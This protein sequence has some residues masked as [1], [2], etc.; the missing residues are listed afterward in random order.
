[1]LLGVFADDLTGAT[2]IAGFLANGGLDVIQFIGVPDSPLPDAD[3]AV[4]SLKSRS[5]PARQAI[6]LSLASVD[7]LRRAKCEQF[8]F[9][10]CSTFDS[11]KDGNIGPV[12]DAVLDQLG[13]NFTVVCPSLPIN[14]RTVRNG[15]LYVDGIPLSE[16]GMRHHPLNPMTESDVCRIMEM[17][18]TGKAGLIDI[19]TIHHGF[20][21]VHTALE[22][23]R[24]KG[25]RY[26][27]L[28]AETDDDLDT[29]A[30]AVDDLP[31]IT[32][33][34]GLGGAMARRIVSKL[35][36]APGPA[37]RVSIPNGKAIVLSGSCS[38]MTNRQV[39]FY[40]ERAKNTMVNVDL[41][42]DN[43]ESYAMTLAQ[44]ANENANQEN[45]PLIYA[46]VG[47]QE[48]AVIQDRHGAE[49]VSQAIE[50]L[51][52]TL[53]RKLDALGFTHFIVAGGE[54]SGSVSEALPIKAF[55]LGPEIA[56]GVPWV[57]G[58]EQPY[59]LALKSGNFGDESFF[60]KAQ[61][62]IKSRT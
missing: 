34:S 23:L 14:K 50:K 15:C 4:I 56:P 61:A 55:R 38:D 1:M 7:C 58:V 18:S 2:D 26:S 33:G 24:A 31:F 12:T 60:A 29:I 51:F 22:T 19:T 41:C 45:A 59:C 49:L 35:K 28:D 3:A 47:R 17:Q 37:N 9:K 11:T 48:L 39:S 21:A 54:T 30:Q 62:L 13:E 36:R 42:L 10:Y 20:D 6:E 43:T 53:T 32:G 8:Y 27:V 57:K 44:W 25:C 52:S 16:T 46:T 5:I 40:K